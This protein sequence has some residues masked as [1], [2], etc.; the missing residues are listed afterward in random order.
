MENR[1][2]ILIQAFETADIDLSEGQIEAFLQYAALLEDWNSRM[3]LTAITDFREVCRK[4]FLDSVFPFVEYNIPVKGKMMDVGSGAGFP[5]VPLKILFPGLEICLVD[6]L[7][8]R[9]GFL[10]EVITTLGLEHINPIHARAEDL[11]L[12]NAFREQFELVTA[13]AVAEL[14]VLEE[15]CLPFVSLN[16]LFLAYKGDNVEE[17]L[18]KSGSALRLLG[19]KEDNIMKY[20]L[21]GTDLGR[22]F[23]I[24]RKREPTPR[25]YPRRAG[26][27]QKNPL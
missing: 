8:K 3:N 6:S 26:T 21:P 22:S 10:N 4:H 25:K 9:I 2:K 23:V 16:G 11:A 19:G 12:D 14:P 27:I 17:E 5:G 15:Y 13:R 1:R 7:N 20:T 24:I 18:K